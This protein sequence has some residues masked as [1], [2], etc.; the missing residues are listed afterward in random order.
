MAW[1]R[2]DAHP[3]EQVSA[4]IDGELDARARR[5]VEAHLGGCEACTAL[6]GELRQTKSMLAELPRQAPARQFVLGPEYAVA[7]RAAPR[8]SSSTFAPVAALTVLV[9]LLFVDAADFSGTS[10]SEDAGGFTSAGA[11][12]RQSESADKG[13][14]DAA[15]DTSQAPLATGAAAES[16]A[17]QPT[18]AADGAPNPTAAA[19]PATQDRS[20]AEEDDFE[21][22]AFFLPPN[23]TAE[24]EPGGISTLR[25]L[26]IV[27]ALTLLASVAFLYLPRVRR[28]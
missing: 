9:A 26:E 20:A 23:A 21:D 18:G 24:A 15:A 12:A 17:N 19:A 8:R 7:R 4:Y 11:P 13:A 2:H 25:V 10:S 27:A 14:G 1:F 22:D 3:E 6:A 28:R 16:S 5:A